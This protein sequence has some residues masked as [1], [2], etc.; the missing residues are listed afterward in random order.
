MTVDVRVASKEEAPRLQA[1]LG[2]HLA[3][4]KQYGEVDA[5]YPYFDAYWDPSERRWPYLIC[6]GTAPIGFALVNSWSPSG[7]GA[8]VSM[9]EFYIAPEARRLGIGRATAA[10]IFLA[11]PGVWELSVMSANS[12]ASRFWPNAIT[13]SAARDLERIEGEMQTIYRFRIG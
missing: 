13:A 6:K 2:E 10:A 5:A 7:R 8:D 4:L 3:E 9:A 12:L 11:H 1:L